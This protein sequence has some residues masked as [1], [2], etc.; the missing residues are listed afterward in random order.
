MA[1][2]A[3]GGA[4]ELDSSL[5]DPGLA[6]AVAVEHTAG[7]R[8]VHELEGGVSADEEVLLGD[9][10]QVGE[11]LLSLGGAVQQ[12]VVTAVEAAARLAILGAQAVQHFGGDIQ[13]LGTGLAAGQIQ[14]QPLGG[15]GLVGG[16]H[17]GIFSRESFAAHLI[18]SHEKFSKSKII[19][20]KTDA[21]DVGFLTGY[22]IAH[23]DEKS[24]RFLQI[25]Q[26]FFH[27]FV[28][29]GFCRSSLQVL[30]ANHAIYRDTEERNE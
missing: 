11:K 14:L 1:V 27:F 4:D 3:G 17:G 6:V 10:Q 29:I 26:N 15:K 16:L 28:I 22:I 20:G 25:L 2:I 13:L 19:I 30:R 7:H 18:V 8:I 24:K 5:S 12:T 23:F 9:T 21:E